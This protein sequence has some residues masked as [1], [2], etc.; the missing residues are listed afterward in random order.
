MERYKGIRDQHS[1]SG[2]KF[3]VCR[4]QPP[5]K[6]KFN[7]G[8]SQLVMIALGGLI[9]AGIFV[10]SGTPILLAGPAVVFS[11][12]IGGFAVGLVMLILAEI[13]SAE[14]SAGSFSQHANKY[15]GPA[16][17]F[18]TGWMYWSAGVFGMA[19][20]ITA[21]AMLSQWWFP[22]VP[23][24]VFSLFFAGLVT[25]INFLDLKGFSKAETWLS[26]V[27]VFALAAFIL[28]GAYFLSSHYP[29]SVNKSVLTGL[30]WTSL[31]P[32]GWFGVYSSM[33]LVIFAY[34][35][36][37]NMIIAA[38]N[39]CNPSIIPKAVFISIILVTILYT[40]SI[41]I[42]LNVVP[43]QSVNP[44]SSPFVV[45]FEKMGIP[46]AGSILNL[47]VLSADLS[48]MNIIMF[49]TTRMLQSLSERKEAPSVFKKS[50]KAGIP[51][52][53]LLASSAFLSLAVFFAYVLPQRIFIYVSSSSV[54]IC[55]F[56]WIIII[57]TYISF[58]K[59]GSNKKKPGGESKRYLFKPVL[60]MLLVLTVISSVPFVPQEFPGMVAGLAMLFVFLAAYF[61][62][63]R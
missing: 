48:S 59:R 7:L 27:K 36:M 51:V 22:H 55:V 50:N 43:W 56:K 23:L 15:L 58:K 25:M 13:S 26:S 29:G 61:A 37:Q 52:Y 20:E 14:P 40:G 12:L 5:D 60:A 47:I 45:V 4:S 63:Y 49:G 33:L 21:A 35:G 39:A 9:G 8:L 16:M 34:A 54:F 17:G 31:L 53:A 11:Y 46:F 32:N 38:T 19:T 10:A 41:A 3:T 18:V 30:Q 57:L 28:L 42:I 24:W 2:Y 62:Y 44:S 6:H 1:H